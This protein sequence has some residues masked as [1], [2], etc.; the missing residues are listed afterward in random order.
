MQQRLS[1]PNLPRE[2]NSRAF[3]S[4]KGNRTPKWSASNTRSSKNGVKPQLDY[5][6]NYQFRK[7]SESPARRQYQ[8]AISALR[9]IE[10]GMAGSPSQEVIEVKKFLKNDLI[11]KEIARSFTVAN[12]A[13]MASAFQHQLLGGCA[14]SEINNDLKVDLGSKRND[15]KSPTANDAINLLTAQD[16]GK[17]LPSLKNS[18]STDDLNRNSLQPRLNQQSNLIAINSRRSRQEKSP[19]QTTAHHISTKSAPRHLE[20]DKVPTKKR[21]YQKTKLAQE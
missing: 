14:I 9:D 13:H 19:Q 16:S 2:K 3:V 4:L 12:Y 17:S 8:A 6:K 15:E 5:L 7:N 18:N 21:M 1:L 10:K 20:S 11:D